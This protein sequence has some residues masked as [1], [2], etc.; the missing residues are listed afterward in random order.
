MTA[1]PPD[2][3]A[4]AGSIVQLARSLGF[5]MGPAV[6]TVAWALGGRAEAGT[7][8]GLGIAA[9]AA[10]AAVLLLAR[11]RPAAPLVPSE[12]PVPAGPPIG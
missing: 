5:A 11:P 10:F 7:R 4:T 2:R 1:A 6:A 9:L 3:I 12:P 8:I